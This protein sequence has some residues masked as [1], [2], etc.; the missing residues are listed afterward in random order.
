MAKD[1][2][3]LFMVKEFG[4][5]L[6]PRNEYADKALGALAV[7]TEVKIKFTRVTANQR[8]RGFYWCMLN[9]AAEVLR[10]STDQPWDEEVLHDELKRM[11]RL[12]TVLTTPSGRE[13]FK[14]QST[15]DRAMSEPER[16][17]WTDRCAT[18]LSTMLQVPITTLMDEAR[19]RD[20][21]GGY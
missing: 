10:D 7:G 14:P 15:S 12:G 13:I 4:N 1:D 17:R 16:A 21:R 8:R 11:L 18:A 5:V 3:P 6:K 9:V 19:R 2:P 20:G